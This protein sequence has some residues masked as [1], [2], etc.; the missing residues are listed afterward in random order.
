MLWSMA[1][2]Q[3]RLPAAAPIILVISLLSLADNAICFSTSPRLRVPQSAKHG[4]CLPA[5]HVRPMLVARRRGVLEMEASMEKCGQ[6]FSFFRAVDACCT[7]RDSCVQILMAVLSPLGD[8]G[9]SVGKSIDWFF[10]TSTISGL[11]TCMPHKIS[12]VASSG[13][14]PPTHCEATFA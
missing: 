9:K 3:Q 8:I 6:F 13:T 12:M 7:G 1:S 14:N 5:G 2:Q 11:P 4:A 10:D